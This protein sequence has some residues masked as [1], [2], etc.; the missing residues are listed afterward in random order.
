MGV[1]LSKGQKVDLT[2]TYPGLSTVI[3]GLGWDINHTG[4]DY[5][6]DA[7]AF[8]LGGNSKVLSDQDFI[9]YN[10]PSGAGGSV[11]YSGDNRTGAGHLDDEQIRI[12][13]NRVPPSIQRIAFSI[14]IH[15][16][17]EKGQNF[18][19]ISNAY[20]RVFNEG[21]QTELIRFNLGRDYTVETAIVAAE[22]YR[23]N[24]EWKFNAIGSGF[25]GGL[26]ALCRNFGV[27]VDDEPA[28]QNSF[29]AQPHSFA[30]PVQNQPYYENSNTYANTYPSSS[31]GTYPPVN[32]PSYGQA[33]FHGGNQ[34]Q[35]FGQSQTGYGGDHIA[36]PRCNSTNVR[37][38]EKGITDRYTIPCHKPRNLR[39]GT[40][41]PNSSKSFSPSNYLVIFHSSYKMIKLLLHF[42]C[43]KYSQFFTLMDK[44]YHL[45]FFGR[46][47]PAIC[48]A[49]KGTG[50]NNS[51]KNIRTFKAHEQLLCSLLL[52]S[53]PLRIICTR[54]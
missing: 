46:V 2:K 24:G 19:H 42:V 23:H 44:L 31:A 18:G 28:P 13:L 7:S 10:N 16:A 1:M 12:D 6:L 11:M 21:N 29:N 39:L 3:V 43:I 9:F 45:P 53:S 36:C 38:E 14:T 54:R 26:G 5:D 35:G 17:Y 15:N 34:Q 52:L 30:P 8:L 47:Q 33:P 48:H 37:T 41:F 51:I 4:A 40:N 49:D 20:V 22:L 27:T 32:Q 50:G 25:Q